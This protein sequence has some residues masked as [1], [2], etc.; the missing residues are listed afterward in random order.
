MFVTKTSHTVFVVSSVVN[1]YSLERGGLRQA[2][3]CPR[4]TKNR[5]WDWNAKFGKDAQGDWGEFCGTHCND[6]TN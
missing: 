1:I 5:Q 2:E 3:L 4:Y 6:E